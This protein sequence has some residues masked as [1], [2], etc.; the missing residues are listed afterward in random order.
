VLSLKLDLSEK[1]ML[2]FSW[3]DFEG[4]RDIITA[5]LAQVSHH[6][7]ITLGFGSFEP[8]KIHSIV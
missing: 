7:A 6:F 4:F 1:T 3:H 5:E 8:W 2:L